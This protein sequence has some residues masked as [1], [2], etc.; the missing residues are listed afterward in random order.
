MTEETVNK[1]IL[2]LRQEIRLNI[3]NPVRLSELLVEVATYNSYLGDFLGEKTFEYEKL[4]AEKFREY[5]NEK[6]SVERAEN[7]C[8]CDT[9]Q[10]RGEMAKLSVLHKDIE[11]IT[12]AIQTKIRILEAELKNKI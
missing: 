7:L 11:R 9:A 10:L 4:R 6:P 8:R 3:N 12:S 2:N 1:K 5:Y